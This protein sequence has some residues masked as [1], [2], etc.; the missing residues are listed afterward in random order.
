MLRDLP[1]GWQTALIGRTPLG[2]GQPRDI[3]GMVAFLAGEEGHWITNE[4]I[5]VDGRAR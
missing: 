5:R 1:E 3:A 2:I 4:K